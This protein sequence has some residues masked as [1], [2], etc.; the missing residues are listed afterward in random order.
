MAPVP[1]PATTP[2]TTP[3]LTPSATGGSV[4]V[5]MAGDTFSTIAKKTGVSVKAIKE[6]NAGL[7]DKKLQIGHKLQIPPSA[8]VASAEAPKAAGEAASA[9]SGD[10]SVY[11]VKSGDTLGKIATANH[12]SVKV[13]EALNDM[14]TSA[15]KANQ[16]LKI[17]VMKV[18]SADVAPIPAAPVAA[19]APVSGPAAP[20]PMAKAN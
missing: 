4:Y 10:S 5:I 1:V 17:P 7:E 15:I 12:T 13:I 16:K 18:A 9:A 2:V 20:A 3:A 8:A 19:P 11:V 6:A 14:K